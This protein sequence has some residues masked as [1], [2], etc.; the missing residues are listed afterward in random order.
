MMN[1]FGSISKHCQSTE[2]LKGINK[3]SV[4]SNTNPKSH[5]S[6]P[7]RICVKEMIKAPGFKKDKLT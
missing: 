6:Q 5:R 4:R 1:R 7:T 2:S 3:Q